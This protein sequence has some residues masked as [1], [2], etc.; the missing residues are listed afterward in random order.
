MR[1]AQEL[2][3]DPQPDLD[4]ID[5]VELKDIKMLKY[6]GAGSF[7]KVREGSMYHNPVAVKIL[8]P[9]KVRG[10]LG[11]IQ[12]PDVKVKEPIRT[13]LLK[14][15]TFVST[16]RGPAFSGILLCISG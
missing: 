12:T 6:L 11:S 3:A 4:D 9:P 8:D 13:A 14:V 10:H 16:S 1:H 7:G 15:R 5:I 2:S